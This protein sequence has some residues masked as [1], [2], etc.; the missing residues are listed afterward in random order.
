MRLTT[1]LDE[2]VNGWILTIFNQ[3]GKNQYVYETLREAQLHRTAAE[4]L[5]DHKQREGVQNAATL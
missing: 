2:A 5:Y 3:N 4:D 1:I